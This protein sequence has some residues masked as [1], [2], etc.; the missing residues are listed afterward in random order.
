[1]GFFRQRR[2]FHK[3]S[4]F[5]ALL[6]TLK[7]KNRVWTQPATQIAYYSSSDRLVLQGGHL[8]QEGRDAG[9]MLPKW[10]CVY[11]YVLFSSHW[12]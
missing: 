6:A 2:V 8:V 1:M 12:K 5:Q 11:L 3:I 4:L 9:T 7:D 10:E